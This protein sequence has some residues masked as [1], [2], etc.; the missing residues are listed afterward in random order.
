M[1]VAGSG[2]RVFTPIRSRQTYADLRKHARK[3]R[4]GPITVQ[5]LPQPD[6]LQSQVAYAI[7]RQCGGAVERN[8]LRR[9]MRAV[10]GEQAQVLPTGAYLVRSSPD[11]PSLTYEQLKEAMIQALE[12]ATTPRV[13]PP[14]ARR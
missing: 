10:L 13:T 4:N 8:R 5:F 1:T 6:W 2:R 9:R 11:G 14:G 7:G 3:G 12:K